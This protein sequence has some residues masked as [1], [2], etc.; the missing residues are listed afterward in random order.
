MTT[1]SRSFWDGSMSMHTYIHFHMVSI[2]S[3]NILLREYRMGKSEQIAAFRVFIGKS[4]KKIS[5]FQT[6][7]IGR[8]VVLYFCRK[9]YK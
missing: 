7:Q 6:V 2:R 3:A 8:T 1:E 9:F 4:G 5:F